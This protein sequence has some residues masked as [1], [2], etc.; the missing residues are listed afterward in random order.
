M[1]IVLL[2]VSLSQIE[3]NKLLKEFPQ[4]IFLS[5]SEF[6]Y[7]RLS[8]Q[9]WGKVEIIFGD[10]ISEDE[11]AKAQQLR[12]IHSPSPHLH[13]ICMKA[14]EKQGNILVTNTKEEN[15]AQIGEYV[16]AGVLSFAKLLFRWKE[17]NHSPEMVWDS[18]WRNQMWS[19]ED[20]KFLQI[21]LGK[22]GSEISKRAKQMGMT[23]W[24]VQERESFHEHCHK[25]FSFSDI[26]SILPA[27]D[28]VSI[29]LPRGKHRDRWLG[30]REFELMKE[31]SILSIVGNKNI[32]D[33]NGFFKVASGGK[34]RGI[35]FDAFY[36]IP[37]PPSSKLWKLPNILITPEVSPRPKDEIL[38]STRIFRSNLR[39]YQYG[40]ITDMKNLVSVR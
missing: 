3:F 30:E 18:K 15:I 19:M 32:V 34:F 37:I 39:Q 38:L 14:I 12:W 21:G 5:L 20:R 28:V 16:T 35:L 40:N 26:H 7:K 4:Y 8:D 13:R 27:A 33:E 6:D 25:T 10:R 29:A 22:V 17:V 24:G 11:L 23:V 31:G 9:D 36:Q 1:N 2:Q